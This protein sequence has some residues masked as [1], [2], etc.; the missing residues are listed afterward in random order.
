MS[1]NKN[2][3]DALEEQESGVEEID[4]V[5]KEKSSFPILPIVVVIS[6]LLAITAAAGLGVSWF[7]NEQQQLLHTQ[8]LLSLK[9]KLESLQQ[10]QQAN[11]N[12]SSTMQASLNKQQQEIAKQLSQITEKLGRNQHD[13]A[14]AEIRYTLRQAN[15]RLQLFKDKTT[16]LVAL[17]IA[18]TQLAKL[19][20]PALYKLRGVVN[21]EIAAL[22]A[23]KEIDLEGVSLKL[24]AL[25]EQVAKLDVSITRRSRA[26]NSANLPP[27]S[28]AS[29][30]AAWQK[31]ADAIWSELKTLVT[32]RRT[33]K[34]I[35]PLLSE[36][37]SQQLRQA[38]GL[39]IEITRLALLQQNTSLFRA[40][41]KAA[42]DWLEEY[43]NAEQPA[44]MAI[45][46]ELKSLMSLQLEPEYP[47]I[48]GSLAM[49]G[50]PAV[51]KA[52]KVTVLSKDKDKNLPKVKKTISKKALS[53]K[54]K[55]AQ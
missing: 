14:V 10:A 31:H 48:S 30:L 26:S 53:N 47:D 1:E 40:S 39:K 20:D 19:A 44:V 4:D 50:K 24:S 55:T 36:Q 37:E 27:V 15:M 23:V 17:Q 35:L 46:K 42:N 21:K 12:V 34:K 8:S 18:D 11:K 25:A 13:W 51:V 33:D 52:K 2:E 22:R 38:L 6:L 49:L 7:K 3:I 16:A 9:N 5:V 29:D 41:L 45:T 28:S 43:F 54:E 32:I